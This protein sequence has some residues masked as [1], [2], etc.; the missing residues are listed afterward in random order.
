MA[1]GEEGGSAVDL[2]I[3]AER[4]AGATPEDGVAA[5]QRAGLLTGTARAL[6]IPSALAVTGTLAVTGALAIA[7]A[8]TGA[9]VGATL[10]RTLARAI[11]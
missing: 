6:A 5:V 3:E 7:R 10:A 4:A 11:I 9:I 2:D 8:L 1:R